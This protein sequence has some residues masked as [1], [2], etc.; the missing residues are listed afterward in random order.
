MLHQHRRSLWLKVTLS[1]YNLRV[2]LEPTPCIKVWRPFQWKMKAISLH[3]LT[4]I[5]RTYLYPYWSKLQSPAYSMIA[6]LEHNSSKNRWQNNNKKGN[7]QKCNI[8]KV[9]NTKLM[10]LDLK[11]ATWGKAQSKVQRGARNPNN[12]YWLTKI[13]SILRKWVTA[14]PAYSSLRQIH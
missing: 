11:R 7:S 8:P 13:N 10:M 2:W 6:N 3:L 4:R 1:H 14:R 5:R 12:K 9:M